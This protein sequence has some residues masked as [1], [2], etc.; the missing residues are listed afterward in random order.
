M[1]D[2]QMTSANKQYIDYILRYNFAQYYEMEDLLENNTFYYE[3][4]QKILD[5]TP[6]QD[7]QIVDFDIEELI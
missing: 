4:F 1:N 7:S 3:K 6:E 5:A 2:G